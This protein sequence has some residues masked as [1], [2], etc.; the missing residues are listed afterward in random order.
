MKIKYK[1][2]DVFRYCGT[3]K[4]LVIDPDAGESTY[5]FMQLT[6]EANEHEFTNTEVDTSKVDSS[7]GEVLFNIFDMLKI[8][9]EVIDSK[10]NL[11]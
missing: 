1:A 3:G 8:V 11:V 7:D 6:C 4:V 10:E 9:D 5:S 2:G